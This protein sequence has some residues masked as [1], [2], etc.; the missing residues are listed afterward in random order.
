MAGSDQ[1]EVELGDGRDGLGDDRLCGAGKVE[2]AKHPVDGDIGETGTRLG[3]HVDQAGMRAGGED[4]LALTGDMHG[5]EA[6]VHHHLVKLPDAL[7]VQS[8]LS[9]KTL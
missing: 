4:D 3:K 7:L 6:L 1:R 2:A 5:D 9:G 8:V